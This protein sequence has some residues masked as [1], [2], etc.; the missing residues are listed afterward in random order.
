MT[1]GGGILNDRWHRSYDWN[2]MCVKTLAV[3]LILV[4]MLAAPARALAGTQLL[5]ALPAVGLIAG[6][7]GGN[8][9][10][11]S[12]GIAA[13][14]TAVSATVPLA[15]VGGLFGGSLGLHLMGLA[16]GT[17]A[18]LSLADG[19]LIAVAVGSTA[20][21]VAATSWDEIRASVAELGRR[22]GAAIRWAAAALR[23]ALGFDVTLEAAE[24]QGPGEWF[25][26]PRVQPEAFNAADAQGTTV[27]EYRRITNPY[28]L[29]PDLASAP[30]T[31]KGHLVR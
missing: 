31:W 24:A 10:G 15:V 21:A 29:V 11:T 20:I 17:A 19:I 30:E 3:T 2:G 4:A 18:T 5:L 25:V 1:A 23:S 9:V 13:F 22:F 14:G 6:M 12:I 8:V 16:G 28:G 26:G 27:I 7:I